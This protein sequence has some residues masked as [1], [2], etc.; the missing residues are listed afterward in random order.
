M[1]SIFVSPMDENKLYEIYIDENKTFG[2]FRKMVA[3]KINKDSIHTLITGR[4]E[5]NG[6][7]N[8]KI[9]REI[10]GLSDGCSLYAVHQLYG[11]NTKYK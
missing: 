6:D 1:W 4:Y 5:Y 7:Y 10:D 8:S 9:I 11:G 2:E 3:N